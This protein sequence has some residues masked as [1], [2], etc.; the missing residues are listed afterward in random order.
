MLHRLQSPPG[1]GCCSLGFNVK[2]ECLAFFLLISCFIPKLHQFLN[3]WTNMITFWLLPQ[4]EAA[5]DLYWMGPWLV[6]GDPVLLS[7]PRTLHLGLKNGAFSAFPRP[8]PF[9]RVAYTLYPVLWELFGKSF[10]PLLQQKENFV[11]HYLSMLCP[12]V[13]YLP[14]EAMNLLKM[15]TWVLHMTK[16]KF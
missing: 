12:R 5:R 15:T 3:T 14:S 10:L 2:S 4:Q 7:E 11:L 16:G 8:T 9:L 1:T 13:L 6:I